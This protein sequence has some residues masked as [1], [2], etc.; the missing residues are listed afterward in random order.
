MNGGRDAGWSLGRWRRAVTLFACAAGFAISSEHA[1]ATLSFGEYQTLRTADEWFEFAVNRTPVICEATVVKSAT[2]VSNGE[3]TRVYLR[4]PVVWKGAPMPREFGVRE[5]GIDGFLLNQAKPGDRW[6][7]Y[8]SPHK[9]EWS[10]WHRSGAPG[11]GAIRFADLKPDVRRERVD[12]LLALARFDSLLTHAELVVL[13]HSVPGVWDTAGAGPDF[14]FRLRVDHTF[15]GAAPSDTLF[16]HDKDMLKERGLLFLKRRGTDEW[17][18]VR[19][20]AGCVNFD[21][22]NRSLDTGEPLQ[23]YLTRIQRAAAVPPLR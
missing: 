16:I 11:R 2:I 14:R 20:G 17:Q 13:A 8:L 5:F 7:L 19:P 22:R 18:C 12:S 23:G 1:G 3:G 15:K 21:E 4:D 10:C 9:S 6:L